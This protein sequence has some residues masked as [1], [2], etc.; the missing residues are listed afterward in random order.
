LRVGE[1]ELAGAGRRFGGGAEVRP[2]VEG[3]G[4]V[5]A[6]QHVVAQAARVVKILSLNEI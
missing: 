3:R 6:S 5:V 4:D 2:G 1:L